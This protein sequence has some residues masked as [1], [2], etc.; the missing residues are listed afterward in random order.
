MGF[1]IKDVDKRVKVYLQQRGEEVNI[2]GEDINGR[3]WILFTL[4]KDGG[5]RR[6]RSIDKNVGVAV[7]DLGRI[8]EVE[9]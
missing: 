2:L 3:S 7:D 9:K 1:F 5:F 4:L 8:K 6:I